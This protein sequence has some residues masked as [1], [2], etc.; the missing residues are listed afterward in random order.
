VRSSRFSFSS[1]SAPE[2]VEERLG[3]RACALEPR[4]RA[5]L[6]G[7]SG[8]DGH[9]APARFVLARAGLSAVERAHLAAAPGARMEEHGELVRLAVAPQ[10]L[11]ELARS[12]EAARILAS[13]LAAAAAR[14]GPARVMGIVNV[15]P[16]SFSDGGEHLACE[17]ALAHGRA[18]D[19][20]GA[21][22]VDV[23]GESTRPGAERVP[24]ALQI[25]RVL[26]VVAGLSGAVRAA[27][28]VDTTSAEVARAALAAGARVV[29]DV[30]AG[31]DDPEMLAC[32]AEHEAGIVLMHMQGAPRDMQDE[33]HYADVV[34]EVVAF[35]RARARAAVNAGVAAERIAVDPGIGFGKTLAH[36]LALLRA[37][38]ELRSLG[39]PIVLGVSRKGL[40]G[41]LT[42]EAVPARRGH[43]TAALVALADGLGADVHRVHEVGAAR[44]AL[45]VARALVDP[46]E[47]L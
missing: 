1:G 10:V 17:R 4:V 24:A 25:E 34:R 21:D 43:A 27:I 15:T 41:T 11:S 35:L 26:P 32:V 20:E 30:S 36:N 12:S 18:M 33:P 6:P 22:L 39:F 7:A 31:R 23:G 47:G 9:G 13:A 14:R 29:N 2:R 45:S 16:D 19:A 46:E 42:G 37:L 3:E 5:P 28:S 38:P 40:L 8:T 44:A